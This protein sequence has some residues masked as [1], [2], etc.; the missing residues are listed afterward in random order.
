MCGGVVGL[1]GYT[2]CAGASSVIEHGTCVAGDD[3]PNCP[4][5]RKNSGVIEHDEQ[6]SLEHR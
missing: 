4:K 3:L 1:D 5:T 2:H 6:E